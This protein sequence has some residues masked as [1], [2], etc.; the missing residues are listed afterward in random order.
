MHH[1]QLGSSLKFEVFKSEHTITKVRN[2]ERRAKKKHN[3]KGHIHEPV[4]IKEKDT[5]HPKHLGIIGLNK[6]FDEHGKV[7][8]IALPHANGNQP[9]HDHHQPLPHAHPHPG[10][11]LI[12][13][14]FSAEIAQ[15]Y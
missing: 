13:S 11:S 7:V 4:V 1:Q 2:W 14:K 15:F 3:T 9:H 10:N 5:T 8:N 12:L 6:D